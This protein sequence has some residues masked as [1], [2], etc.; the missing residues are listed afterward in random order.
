MTR[1]TCSTLAWT[2]QELV[3][4]SVVYTALTASHSTRC[5]RKLLLTECLNCRYCTLYT[6][7]IVHCTLY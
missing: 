2:H 7:Y 4:P 3:E 5:T 1:I 6:L